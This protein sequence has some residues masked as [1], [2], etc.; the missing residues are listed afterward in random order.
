MSS[1]FQFNQSAQAT[2]VQAQSIIPQI[3]AEPIQPESVNAASTESV[4]TAEEVAEEPQQCTDDEETADDYHQQHWEFI[5]V[6]IGG[7]DN[8]TIR[9]EQPQVMYGIHTQH[10]VTGKKKII[11]CV[12]KDEQLVPM[13][14]GSIYEGYCAHPEH[15]ALYLESR[16]G[17]DSSSYCMQLLGKVEAQAQ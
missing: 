13:D 9:W 6:R 5:S 12:Y 3:K 17:F 1:P 15:G 2:E 8:G 14:S 7:I 11:L 16:A 10:K 4:I